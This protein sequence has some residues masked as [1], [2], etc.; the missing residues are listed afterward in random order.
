MTPTANPYQALRP[1]IAAHLEKFV[2]TPPV[3]ELTAEQVRATVQHNIASFTHTPSQV[4][5]VI[6]RTLAT[7]DGTVRAR[8][9]TPLTDLRPLPVLVYF[10]GGG[11]VAGSVETVDNICRLM[12]NRCH[13]LVVSIDYPLAPEHK[14]PYIVRQCYAALQWVHQR[15]RT[16]GGDARRIAVA[17]DSSGA[18]LAAAMT[19][20]A[21]DQQQPWPIMFQALICPVTNLGMVETKSYQLFADYG[22]NREK[23]L[24]FRQQYLSHHGD[25]YSPYAS[26]LLARDLSNLPPA[27]VV[28]AEFDV[29]RDDGQHYAEHLQQAKVP[30]TLHC[31]KGM[32]HSGAFWATAAPVIADDIN[33]V[34]Q[35]IRIHLHE[36]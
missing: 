4:E 1:E 3:E 20:M 35:Q 18:N 7:S 26:P 2:K 5:S 16:Y 17:G 33:F 27:L 25:A 32:V 15:I 14:F 10:H 19:L 29:L 21:K 6:D 30:T 31:M 11:W 12:A 24:W 28:T 22:L 8:F 34:C 13:C 36:S 23:M 9:Y